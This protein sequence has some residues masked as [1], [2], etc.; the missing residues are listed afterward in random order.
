MATLAYKKRRS[1]PLLRSLACNLTRSSEVLD[2]KQCTDLLFGSAV[3][4]FMDINL[5]TKI[6]SDVGEN[7]DKL[8]ADKGSALVG[9]LL[10]SVGVLRYK[11]SGA[12]SYTIQN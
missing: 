9:S 8:Q 12:Y 1:M 7:I 4:N 2:V 10:T 6:A 3:L 5:I 11:D